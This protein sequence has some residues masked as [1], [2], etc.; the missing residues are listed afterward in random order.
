MSC[1]ALRAFALGF[2]LITFW[3]AY[4]QN[5]SKANHS[6]FDNDWSALKVSLS[7][8]L[9]SQLKYIHKFPKAYDS[10]YKDV[11]NREKFPHLNTQDPEI[12]KL[13]KEDIEK[14]AKVPCLDD[15]PVDLLKIKIVGE[16]H[17]CPNCVAQGQLF[18]EQNAQDEIV[19]KVEND[20]TFDDQI[21]QKVGAIFTLDKEMQE[22]RAMPGK[23]EDNAQE[24][25]QLMFS[26]LTAIASS[27]HELITLLLEQI[28][29]Q[30]KKKETDRLIEI[31]SYLKTDPESDL[32]NI[33]AMNDLYEFGA[34]HTRE[35]WNI[36][37]LFA[38]SLSQGPQLKKYLVEHGKR[39]PPWLDRMSALS[40]SHDEKDQNLFDLFAAEL[41]NVHY[42]NLLMTEAFSSA[43]CAKVKAGFDLKKPFIIEVGYAHAF[44]LQAMLN[45]VF[46]GASKTQKAIVTVDQQFIRHAKMTP[47]E[48][49]KDLNSTLDK[50]KRY[51]KWSCRRR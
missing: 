37:K 9:E 11:E 19:S 16:A 12:I 46:T 28:Q 32:K 30:S 18:T 10:T 43:V 26:Y 4:G 21:F 8:D 44:E 23:E 47:D 38:H 1:F 25:I 3:T 22:I 20:D 17:R 24:A 39:V 15:I 13:V 50:V 31:F 40:E 5:S 36:G 51:S 45:E 14:L 27:D 33:K 35:F 49:R 41:F 6:Q 29:N 2:V 42:R 48:R 7:K 34:K